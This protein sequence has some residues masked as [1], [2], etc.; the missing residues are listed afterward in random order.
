[1]NHNEQNSFNFLDV[2][3]ILAFIIQVLDYE[4]TLS[5]VGNNDILK[6][7]RSDMAEIRQQ[8]NEIKCMIAETVKNKS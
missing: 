2:L 5:Q 7:L 4:A 3:A 1:M 8:N 6:E